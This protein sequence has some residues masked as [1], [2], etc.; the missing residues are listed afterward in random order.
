[1][2]DDEPSTARFSGFSVIA[3]PLAIT[4]RP[5]RAQRTDLLAVIPVICDYGVGIGAE[6]VQ[7]HLD[8]G[9]TRREAESRGQR[10]RWRATQ[11]GGA[12]KYG[13]RL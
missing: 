11:R 12:L 7:Q 4:S 5:A 10:R 6:R 9:A 13:F 3:P 1:M 8:A 2:K